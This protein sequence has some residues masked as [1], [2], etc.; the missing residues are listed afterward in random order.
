MRALCFCLGLLVLVVCGCRD[1]P[2]ETSTASQDVS[3]GYLDHAQPRLPV[4]QLWLGTNELKTEVAR[5]SVQLQTGM[6]YRQS[7]EENEAMIF[8]FQF[9]HRA[10]FYMRNTVIPLSC[11]YLDSEGTILEIHDLKPLDENS[12]A[13]S[14]DS[15]QFVLETRQGW[16]ERHQLGVGTVVTTSQGP[17]S[18]VF[19]RRQ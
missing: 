13:A 16:F 1:K 17:L 11:G 4:I 14:S 10:A 9:P 3:P 18:K 8:V 2:A 19:F 12:V 7:M 5:T 6:M 15:V